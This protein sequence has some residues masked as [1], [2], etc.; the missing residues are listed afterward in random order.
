VRDTNIEKYAQFFGTS[1]TKLLKA[2]QKSVAPSDPLL[3]D[4]NE[5]HLEIARSYMRARKRVRA[6]IELLLTT[7]HAAEE[8]LTTLVMKLN[9]L[10]PDRLAQL[11]ALVSTD[12]RTAQFIE[13]VRQR[14]VAD[15]HF[16]A[17][18][19]GSLNELDQQPKPK[20]ET[21]HPKKRT[22]AQ[23]RRA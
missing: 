3:Q 1:L 23:T 13:R 9:T 11:D 15:P 10:S 14:L 18:L 17:L 19:E 2:D 7:E 4:L 16:V 8:P 5:E 21:A 22:P 12:D 6:C 20:T